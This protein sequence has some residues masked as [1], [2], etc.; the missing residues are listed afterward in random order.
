MP[1]FIIETTFRLPVYRS[2]RYAADTLAEACSLAIADDDWSQQ[3]ED[4]DSSGDTYVTGIW[5]EHIDPYD[6]P[7]LAIP[8]EFDEL[9]QRKADCFDALIALATSAA[10]IWL[11]MVLGG[12]DRDA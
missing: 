2:R 3:K 1:I 7:T 5:P 6:V 12:S 8:A 10:I 4:I 11:A 9:V